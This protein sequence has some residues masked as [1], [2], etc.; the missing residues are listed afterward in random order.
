[1]VQKL[2]TVLGGD[3]IENLVKPAVLKINFLVLGESPCLLLD[4]RTHLAYF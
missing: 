1:M 3:I 2:P 4:L